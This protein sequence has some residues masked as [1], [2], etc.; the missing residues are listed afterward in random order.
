[1]ARRRRRVRAVRSAD[2]SP[3]AGEQAVRD[4][5]AIVCMAWAKELLRQN[6]STAIA[7]HAA[8]QERRNAIERLVAAQ[9]YGDAGRISA[10]HAMLDDAL[11]VHCASQAASER[12]RRALEA[13]LDALARSR[14][15]YISAAARQVC[16][17]PVPAAAATATPGSIRQSPSGGGCLKNAGRVLW[18]LGLLLARSAPGRGCGDPLRWPMQ[19]D[20]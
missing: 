6:D 15:E 1:M 10:A 3:A 20:L 5:E 9:R 17:G 2:S 12:V 8:R 4:A 14:K 13:V 7:L 19:T 18:R 16:D 11:E